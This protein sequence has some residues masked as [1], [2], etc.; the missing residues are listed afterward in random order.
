MFAKII[1]LTIL[2]TPTENFLTDFFKEHFI[3][4]VRSEESDI[5]Q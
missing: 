4:I 3:R 2:A 5:C 1:T